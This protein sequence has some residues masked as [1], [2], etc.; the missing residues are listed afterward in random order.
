VVI[1]ESG[2]V[3]HAALLAGSSDGLIGGEAATVVH[4][5]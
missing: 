4:Q 5:A 2:R 1:V 3:L